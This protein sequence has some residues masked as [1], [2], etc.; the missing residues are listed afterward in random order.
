MRTASESASGSADCGELGTVCSVLERRD[1]RHQWA[2][3]AMNAV[4]TSKHEGKQIDGVLH[5]SE[6]RR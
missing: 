4:H 6:H 5:Q 3:V 2:V 1:V